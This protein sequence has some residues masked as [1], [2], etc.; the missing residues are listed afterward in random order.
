MAVQKIGEL[1]AFAEQQK[2]RGRKTSRQT[3]RRILAAF[4]SYKRML[5]LVLLSI[6]C[7]NVVSLVVPLMIPLVFDDALAHHNMG[8]LIIYGLIMVTATVI[9]GLLSVFQ[10]YV[11]NRVGQNVMR[12]FRRRLYAHLQDMSL[13][14]FTST[15]TGEI[16]SRLSNDVSGAQVAVTE[17]F[18]SAVSSIIGMLATIVA[19]FYLSPFLALISFALLPLFLFFTFRVGNVRRQSGRAT[20]QSMASL[21]ALMQETLSVSGILLIKTFG[22]K[23]FA[24]EQ[25]DDENHKLTELSLRQQMVGLWFFMFVSTFSAFTPV[26][27]YILAGWQ[28]INHSFLLGSITIGSLIAFI[29]LQGRFFGPFVQLLSLQVNVQGAL[30]LFDRIFEYLDMPIELKD[31]PDAL[32][33]HP[34]EVCGEICFN[35]VSFTYKSDDFGVL[36]TSPEKK[37][38]GPDS[39]QSKN[40]AQPA[41]LP[42]ASKEFPAHPTLQHVSFEVHPGQLVAL[43]GPSGAGKTTITYLLP[44]LYDVDSGSIE[45]DGHNIRDISLASL[46][47]LIGVVTQETYLFHASIRKNLLYV[48]PDATEEEIIAAAKAAAIHDR[49][50]E[51]EDGYDTVV[52]ERGYRLSGGEKQRVAIA[53]VLLKNPRILILDEATSALD[54]HSERFIQAALRPLMAGRTTIAIAH[55][56]STILAAD[57]I[58]VVDKGEI[59]ERGTHQELLHQEGLYAKL[60]YQQF[61]SQLEESVQ[62]H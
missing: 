31:S 8:H 11:N 53:R 33:L 17:T 7:T 23:Q 24:Q 9:S 39:T 49:I 6:I 32:P 22:R 42:S 48:R 30:A 54:T 51:L 60:Y 37:R 62:Q 15:R 40:G 61:A 56:L 21:N 19:M 4:K 57:Q 38:K 2:A 34:D 28:I 25:F 52:G 43:V 5:A 18:T 58:L 10:I 27:L 14:F 13:R 1:S 16:Q 45:I 29:T 41:A 3:V 12:D 20:Q 36:S 44:R 35:N 47:T 55:R 46:G 59:L 26:I 50:M